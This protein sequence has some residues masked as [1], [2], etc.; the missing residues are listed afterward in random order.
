MSFP[1]IVFP[2]GDRCLLFIFAAV[3]FPFA[4]VSD[5]P[6]EKWRQGRRS[7][8][9]PLLSRPHQL[10]ASSLAAFYLSA[11]SLATQ[12]QEGL[13]VRL[14]PLAVG[15]EEGQAALSSP[16]NA[17]GLPPSEEDASFLQF[18]CVKCRRRGS[19]PDAATEGGPGQEGAPVR[20]E[21]TASGAGEE[22][23]AKKKKRSLLRRLW[24]R[25]RGRRGRSRS[26]GS[27]GP[28]GFVNPGFE[29]TDASDVPHLGDSGIP[30]PMPSGEVEVHGPPEGI[31]ESPAIDEEGG[32]EGDQMKPQK[33]APP[34][35]PRR[36]APHLRAQAEG[37]DTTGG[38][39]GGGGKIAPPEPPRRN[40][41]HLRAQ[42]GDGDT[43]GGHGGGGGKI[44]PPK[45]PRRNAPHLRAQAEGGDTT[46]GHGG[47]G[48]KIAPPKPP[49]RNAPH[50]RAQAGDGDTTGGHG[51]EEEG[52]AQKAP[53]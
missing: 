24:G 35:P 17:A 42:A 27:G 4:A 1:F 44:A 49:R 20:S 37:G 40:A 5:C 31:P 28:L 26:A 52:A 3:G 11:A 23:G 39:G 46:G 53:W 33:T 51:D 12:P 15:G 43:T 41:P 38:H 8:A 25:I 30:Q 29:Q 7:S 6:S 14:G 34:E 45:P 36:N 19:N 32:P 50:L 21:G 18:P 9:G 10:V 22:G 47:G 2:L 16:W 13:S 48:G